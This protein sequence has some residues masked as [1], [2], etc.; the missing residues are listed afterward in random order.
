MRPGGS[1][2]ASQAE[3]G[4]PWKAATE[5]AQVTFLHSLPD[6][7]KGVTPP[8]AALALGRP[9]VDLGYVAKGLE[10]TERRAWYMRREGDHYLFRTRASINKRYQERLIDLQQQPSEVKRVLDDWIKEVYSGFSSLQLIPF[11]ADHTAIPDSPERIRLALVH[12]DKEVGYV[13]PG[14][15]S[16]LTSSRRC[17]LRQASTPDHEPIVTTSYSSWPKGPVSRGSRMP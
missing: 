5:A 17:S 3:A 12:Y 9:G 16:G 8:E 1:T 13:G 4:W 11:P 14:A 15:A 10:D 7:S 6:G 2:H